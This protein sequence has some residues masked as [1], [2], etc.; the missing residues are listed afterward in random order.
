M[1][2]NSLILGSVKTR[3]SFHFPAK[4]RCFSPLDTGHGRVRYLNRFWTYICTPF[5][6]PSARMSSWSRGLKN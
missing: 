2:L 1:A 3:K 4:K 6:E 5:L